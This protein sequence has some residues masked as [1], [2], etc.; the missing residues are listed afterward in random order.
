MITFRW[1]EQCQQ[2][3]EK[4]KELLMEYPVL[5][6]PSSNSIFVLETDAS[7]LGTGHCLKAL[8]VTGSITD[9]KTFAHS[10]PDKEHNFAYGKGC[11]FLVE[12]SLGLVLKSSFCSFNCLNDPLRYW[13]V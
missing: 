1:T 4:V 10:N 5:H 6:P 8:E 9:I 3:F 12:P 2:A 11:S 7:D 13:S